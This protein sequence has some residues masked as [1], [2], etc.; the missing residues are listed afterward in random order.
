MKEILF[1]NW[2]FMRCL[3][4]GIGSYFM[5]VAITS[6]ESVL[7]FLSAFFII[8]AL[9]NT[10]CGVNGCAPRKNTYA[11]TESEELDYEIIKPK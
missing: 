11:K 3:R 8:Q 5:Y 4:L 6:G 10:G 7:G 2:D 9:T 1:S